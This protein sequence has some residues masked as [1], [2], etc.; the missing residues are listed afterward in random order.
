MRP[1]R[2]RDAIESEFE[3]LDDLLDREMTVYLL[4]GGAMTFRGLKDGTRD[5]DLLVESRSDFERLRDRLCE[6][7]Y[8]K[9]E[10]PVD[11]YASLGAAIVLDRDGACRFDVFDREVIRK[12]RLS[13]GM[14]NRAEEV[15]A[16]GALRAC[17]LSNEDVFLFKGVAGRSRDAEDM[18]RV[19][20]AGRGLDFDVITAEF[21]AQLPLNTGG[22]ELELLRDAPENHP[23]IAVERAVLSLPMTLPD[24]FTAVVES[25]AD[26]VQA[27]FALVDELDREATISRLTETLESRSTVEVSGRAGTEAVVD[28]LVEKEVV[29][30]NGDAVR[31]REFDV[32]S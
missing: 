17:A 32:D 2:G 16:G 24:S 3:A 5:L 9:V 11:E 22:V 21:R 29:V 20:Q 19:V 7:G 15:F 12:L 18:G 25:E 6:R 8:E 27:E 30:R 26:R 28:S 4:G 13:D 23:V 1:I 10:N 14:K 31:L